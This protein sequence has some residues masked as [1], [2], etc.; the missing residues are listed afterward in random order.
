M[1][2]PSQRRTSRVFQTNHPSHRKGKL[3]HNSQWHLTRQVQ[4]LQQDSVQWAHCLLAACHRYPRQAH[5]PIGGLGL[6]G[7]P[8]LAGYPLI[9]VRDACLGK[10]PSNQLSPALSRE[11]VQLVRRHIKFVRNLCKDS[12]RERK[13]DKFKAC[14][15]N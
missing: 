15:I 13:I 12:G 6:E 5:A 10:D 14:E 8:L 1:P 7:V 3:A 11:V 9:L 4:I 2:S